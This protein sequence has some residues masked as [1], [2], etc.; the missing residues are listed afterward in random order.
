MNKKE[1]VYEIH[2]LILNRKP[3]SS[4]IITKIIFSGETAYKI[5]NFTKESNENKFIQIYTVN[6]CRSLIR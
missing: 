1:S 4:Q 3:S 5:H 6:D 2:K